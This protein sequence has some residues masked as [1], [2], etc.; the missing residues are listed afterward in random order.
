MKTMITSMRALGLMAP[1][2]PSMFVRI[3]MASIGLQMARTDLKLLKV[4]VKP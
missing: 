3:V 2:S 4:K 1:F